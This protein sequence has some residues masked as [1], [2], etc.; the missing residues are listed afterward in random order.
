MTFGILTILFC[1]DCALIFA[2]LSY[3][4]L[5]KGMTE[6]RSLEYR[7]NF[8]LPR[9][10]IVVPTYNEEGNIEEKIENISN[11]DYPQERLD[12]MVI[13]GG[14]EDDTVK[15]AERY[16]VKA[17]NL[18][19]RGKVKAINKGIE[20]SETDLL[21][22]T[23]ADVILKENVLKNSLKYLK[24][25]VKAVGG[26]SRLRCDFDA[27]YLEGK[28]KYHEDDWDLRYGESLLDTCCSLDGKYILL[29]KR[30]IEK[31]DE[32]SYVDDLELTIQLRRKGFRSITAEDCLMEEKIKNSWKR[33]I[34]QMRRRCKLSILTSL[35]NIKILFENTGLYGRFIFPLRRLLNFLLPFLLLFGGIYLY[36]YFPGL[37]LVLILCELLISLFNKKVFYYNILLISLILA[38]VDIFTGNFKGG[39]RWE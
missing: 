5:I 17:I 22:T 20:E 2:I 24:K 38:W 16:P 3:R 33:E 26:V 39:A 4:R 15:I 11:L 23:D 30:A 37:L 32:E 8:E 35:Q 10:T 31:I 27:F 9:I 25:N 7:E 21:V 18:G 19:E 6:D 36:L 1:I 12:V 34:N 14:S 28:K 13:D 29:D